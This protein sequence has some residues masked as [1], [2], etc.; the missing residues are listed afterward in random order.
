MGLRTQPKGSPHSG[1]QPLKMDGRLDLRTSP[2]SS[3]LAAGRGGVPNAPFNCNAAIDQRKASG[4]DLFSSG[5]PYVAHK[6]TRKPG[7]CL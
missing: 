5:D 2:T 3:L 6:F 1:M 7:T 4:R